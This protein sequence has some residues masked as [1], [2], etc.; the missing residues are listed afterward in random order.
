ME[1][2]SREQRLSWLKKHIMSLELGK[3]E[4]EKQWF[5]DK[6]SQI[7]TGEVA[8]G[9]IPESENAELQMSA[10]MGA[11]N[12]E[13]APIEATIKLLEEDG[14]FED[15][16]VFQKDDEP[17]L[18][19]TL[20]KE[21]ID[22]EQDESN[23]IEV[24][25]DSDEKISAKP[26]EQ[27]QNS[28]ASPHSARQEH[29]KP[30]NTQDA[31]FKDAESDDEYI[32]KPAEEANTTEMSIEPE[33]DTQKEERSPNAHAAPDVQEKD[34][35]DHH[36]DKDSGEVSTQDT[37]IEPE[38]EIEPEHNPDTH[39]HEES[40][41]SLLARIS[42]KHGLD[43]EP[44]PVERGRFDVQADFDGAEPYDSERPDAVNRRRRLFGGEDNGEDEDGEWEALDAERLVRGTGT[45]SWR[46]WQQNVVRGVRR[47]GEGLARLW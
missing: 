32:V 10:K 1:Q 35:A 18:K 19:V 7:D 22:E 27:L 23:S 3:R 15:A 44:L 17:P 11:M 13:Q 9:D 8:I 14:K 4:A 45:A 47:R 24:K 41:K 21:N 43:L 16:L 37:T 26:P 6:I 5:L 29:E 46:E 34:H 2:W 42:K 39:P 12:T 40:T 33:K 38:T 20:E 25:Y 31:R 28:Q 36:S 30:S